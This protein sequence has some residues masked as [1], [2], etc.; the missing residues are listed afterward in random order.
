MAKKKFEVR[1]KD[2]IL[3]RRTPLLFAHRGGAG[4]VPESTEEAF[5]HA[6]CCGADVLE[7]D[8]GLTS[9]GELVVWHGPG[10]EKVRGKRRRYTKRDKIGEFRWRDLRDKVW[11]LDPVSEP[12]FIATPQRRLLT[13]SDFFAVVAKLERE[14]DRMGKART[15]DI[16]IE[17][18]KPSGEAPNWT[19]S[20]IDRLLDIVDKEPRRRKII[21]ASVGHKRLAAVRR[22]MAAR[23]RHH[24]TNLSWS[25]QCAF[26]EYM[27]PGL[28]TPILSI[29]D[30][31]VA[32]EKCLANRAFETSHALLGRRLVREVRKRDGSLYV[33]LTGFWPVGG[34][35]H[36]STEKLREP[37]FKLLDSGV[38]G[39]MTDYPQRVGALVREWRKANA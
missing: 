33:F 4:E 32:E 18:K 6:V 28:V 16:N 3:K 31:S 22:R 13:L 14:L 27:K 7:L 21:L 37:L 17:L 36:R 5:R 1:R 34:I 39:I 10:L 2:P 9:D 15:L 38:D 23:G 12:K 24:P 11:V 29:I 35:D 25:E 19:R 8:V 20:V 30:L 26:S